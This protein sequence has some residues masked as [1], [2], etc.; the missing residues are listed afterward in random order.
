MTFRTLLAGNPGPVTGPGNN[1]YLIE[2][3]LIDAGVGHASHIAEIERALNGRPLEHV[4]ITHGHSDHS[5]GVPAIR[6]RWAHV[7][8][9]KWFP[10]GEVTP[11]WTALYDDE[12]VRVGQT[13]LR[14]IA[15]PGHAADHICLWD[16]ASRDMFVG[17]MVIAGTTVLV[18]PRAKGG[19]VRAYLQSLARMRDFNPA[20][21]L[22]GHGPA[23]ENPSERIS[24]IIEHRLEREAQI[25]ACVARGIAEP[26]AIVKEIY[27]GLAP[28][29]VP[30]AEQ[31]V[32]AHL[33]KLEEDAQTRRT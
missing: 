33:E 22:P 1:T 12:V 25:A 27:V 3:T 6:E 14:V 21:L 7:R 23:I 30:F 17:D 4:I 28:A 8:V 2:T 32:V 18:S 5:A 20:R 26:S 15:T 31:T 24:A 29:I 16:E 10:H 9:S 19:S 11:G 13:E